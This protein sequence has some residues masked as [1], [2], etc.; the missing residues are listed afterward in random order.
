MDFIDNAL[1]REQMLS[2]AR[3][4][5]RVKFIGISAHE[6]GSCGEPIPEARRQA[7]AGCKVCVYCKAIEEH[8]R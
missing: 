1:D 7:V 4:D 8:R 2:A 5:N 3:L 6:C